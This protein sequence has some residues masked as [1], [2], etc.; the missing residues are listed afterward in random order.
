MVYMSNSDSCCCCTKALAII[1][2]I[3]EDAIIKVKITTNGTRNA[4]SPSTGAVSTGVTSSLVYFDNTI[5]PLCGIEDI[6]FDVNNQAIIDEII[7]ALEATKANVICSGSLRQA[8]DT[9]PYGN[10]FRITST[11]HENLINDSSKPIIA[12]GLNT[13]LLA[14][15][16]TGSTQHSYHLVALCEV[17]VIEYVPIV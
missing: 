17:S 5:I 16:T 15:G 12:T 10:I 6:R 7:A 1:L 14:E 9:E 4:V 3:L 8:I 11:T 13:V 2:Q